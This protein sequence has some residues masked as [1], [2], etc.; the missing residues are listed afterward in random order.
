MEWGNLI[1]A[2][3]FLPESLKVKNHA[4]K[5]SIKP[6][7]GVLRELRKP[8]ISELFWINFIY[9]TSFTMMQM[10]AVLLWQERYGLS[11]KEVG[12]TFAFIGVA[13][14]IVQGGLVGKL[15]TTFGEKKLLHYGSVLMIIG[16]AIIPYMP[17]ESFMPYGLLPMA[18]ITLSNGCMTPS[19][20]A[21]I[22]KNT[23]AHEQ[24]QVLG[25]A[26][27]FGSIARVVGPILGGI[28]YQ[29]DY[30]GPFIGGALLMVLGLYLADVLVRK[31]FV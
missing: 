27:G 15:N 2:F 21:L 30:H 14:A 28:A 9:I 3:L 24:G 13:S 11:E 22:S 7:T 12:Y 19:I 10:T 5:F 8:I 31:Y 18:I 6:I 17:V 26:L 29:Y 23:G 4:K 20:T 16:L 1:M 25:A